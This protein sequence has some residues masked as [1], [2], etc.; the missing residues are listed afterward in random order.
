MTKTVDNFKYIETLLKFDDP[1]KFYFVELF[2]RK[3][4]IS[5]LGVNSRLVKYYTITS[6]EHFKKVE[7]EIKIICDTL[8][9]RAYINLN[10]RSF[11]TITLQMLK[12][13]ADYAASENYKGIINAFQST[14]GSF[15]TDKNKTWILDIDP[16]QETKKLPDLTYLNEM[17]SFID[18]ECEPLTFTDKSKLVATIPTFNG[19]HFIYKPF[20]IN[21]FSNK[22]PNISVHKNNPTLLYFK[23]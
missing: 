1:D 5:D 22:Y 6:L 7:N 8:Q 17:N 2:Q 4:D 13:L 14:C 12:L 23:H 3:K 10:Q 20:N 15:C 19:F 11:K 9:A 18:N 16:D 21:K